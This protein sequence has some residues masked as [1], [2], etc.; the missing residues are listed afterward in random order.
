VRAAYRA[1]AGIT[2]KVQF[3]PVAVGGGQQY[4]REVPQP[5]WKSA[6]FS[7]LRWTDNKS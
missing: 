5:G 3:K 1:C 7:G 2:Q 6:D 4:S